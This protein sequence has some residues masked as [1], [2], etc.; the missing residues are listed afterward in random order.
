MSVFICMFLA[1]FSSARECGECHK[2]IYREWKNSLHANSFSDPVF[3]NFFSQ[4]KDVKLK[5]GC[6]KCHAPTMFL[7][8]DREGPLSEEGVTCDFCHRVKDIAGDSEFPYV[9]ERKKNLKY[10]PFSPVLKS[11]NL[12]HKSEYREFFKSSVF[13][14][15]CHEYR[16]SHGVYVLDTYREWEN[17]VYAG[18]G[19]HCQNCHMAEE[20]EYR[21]VDP[22]IYP[23][24]RI[25]TAHRFLG[26]HSQINIKNAAKLTL[27]P[28]VSKGGVVAT[29]YVEN[30]ESGHHLPTGIPIRKVILNVYLMNKRGEILGSKRKVYSRVLVDKQY[31]RIEEVSALF[32]NA[33]KVQ[34][35]YRIPPKELKREVFSFPISESYKKESLLMEA[36]LTYEYRVP[37]LEPNVMKIE[38]A[39][40]ISPVGLKENNAFEFT[41]L[42]VLIFI[43]F[44]ILIFMLFRRKK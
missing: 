30:A 11:L 15:G 32:E 9:I 24:E 26:G 13:C 35:D 29:V 44:I 18:K 36:R 31:K 4:I 37:Y 8:N 41:L 12:G 2:D 22:A 25:V 38:M 21:V 39:R 28:G 19:I 6:V 23:S 42:S 5:K 10:G 33:Y 43:G 16:N 27:V 3:Q 20:P 1:F 17:S 40:E 7:T 14:K 34:H